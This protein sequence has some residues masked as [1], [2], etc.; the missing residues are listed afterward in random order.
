MALLFLHGLGFGIPLGIVDGHAL[1]HIPAQQQGF[2]AGVLNF[3]RIGSEAVFVAGYSA[4]LTWLIRRQPI[5]GPLADE[6]AAG[7]PGDPEIYLNALH[8][9]LFAVATGSAVLLILFLLLPSRACGALEVLELL[10]RQPVKP[11][12]GQRT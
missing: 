5:P 6:I 3:F 2:A 12:A 7:Q 8:P 1:S 10:N 4:S 11:E 9:L